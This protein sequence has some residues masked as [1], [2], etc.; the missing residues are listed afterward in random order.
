MGY[1]HYWYRVRSLDTAKFAQFSADAKKLY[2]ALPKGIVI[3]NGEGEGEPEF[4]SDA[5]CFNGDA[6]EGLDHETFAI[7]QVFRSDYEQTD[8]TT[9]MLFDFCKTARKPY[10]LLV[11][12]V[13]L[14]L[15][16]HFPE[17]KVSSD[18]RSGE[19]RDA[20]RFYQSVFPKRMKKALT[21]VSTL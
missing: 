17:C 10:D 18:G 14:A 12:S 11:C 9:G 15:L 6:S 13:L 5:V 7:D 21:F 20:L 4:S 1:T 2:E 19:W 8:G 16:H 3:R